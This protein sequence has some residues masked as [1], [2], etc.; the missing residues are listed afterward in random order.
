MWT[1]VDK[2]DTASPA[3]STTM[4]AL[5]REARL[6]VKLSASVRAALVARLKAPPAEEWVSVRDALDMIMRKRNLGP[7]DAQEFLIKACSRKVR[8]RYRA[9]WEGPP[10]QNPYLERY[11]AGLD[12]KSR[13]A[14]GLM[15]G[16]KL[17]DL[18]RLQ[19]GYRPLEPSKWAGSSID[20]ATGTYRTDDVEVNQSAP[21][22]VNANDLS[23]QLARPPR[24]P[25]PGTTGYDS[26]PLLS[27]MRNLIVDGQ[28]SSATDALRQL[29]KAGH[30]IGGRGTVESRIKRVVKDYGKAYPAETN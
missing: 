20:S 12:D 11:L 14:L 3:L 19:M 26:R 16:T 10:T 8:S 13:N 1:E 4:P 2:R 5:T 6:S 29:L 17:I 15:A 9:F 30:K 7:E 18:L 28:A 22:E 25:K 23:N 27:K 24:G 21:V